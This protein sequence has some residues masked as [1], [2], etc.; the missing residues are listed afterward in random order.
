MLMVI[1][2]LL[3]KP[4]TPIDV[5]LEFTNYDYDWLSFGIT[6]YVY[7]CDLRDH[8][9]WL[10]VFRFAIYVY[11]YAYVWYTDVYDKRITTSP[12]GSSSGR[13]LSIVILTLY[14]D[15]FFSGKGR[16]REAY[17]KRNPWPRHGTGRYFCIIDSCFLFLGYRVYDR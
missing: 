16:G 1:V 3:I 15:I 6:T 11:A 17:D 13:L 4:C 8:C 7:D 2:I 10:R 5:N 9:R 12:S 14:Y